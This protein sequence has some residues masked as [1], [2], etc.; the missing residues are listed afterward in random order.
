MPAE[1]VAYLFTRPL[2]PDVRKSLIERPE[3]VSLVTGDAIEG[4]VQGLRDARVQVT[5]LI[6]GQQTPQLSKVM[7]VVLRPVKAK[8]QASRPPGK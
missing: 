1:T 6:L 8:V 7:A 3:G 5:S 2:P 4:S